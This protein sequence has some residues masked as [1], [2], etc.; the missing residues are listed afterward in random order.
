MTTRIPSASTTAQSLLSTLTS[1]STSSL[2]LPSKADLRCGTGTGG[3]ATGIMAG[4]CYPRPQLPRDG[5]DCGPRPLPTFPK[6]GCWSPL[7]LGALKELNKLDQSRG[8]VGADQLTDAIKNGT[9]DLDGQAASGEYRAFAEWAQ[10]NGA[11][12]TPEARKVMDI[13]SKYAAQAQAR[14]QSGIPQ[15]EYDKMIAEMKAVG[16]NSAKGA[17][18]RLDKMP[19]PISGEDFARA[20]RQGVGDRDGQTA[21]EAKAI[22]E[23]AEKNGSKLSPEAKEVLGMFN[24]AADK[25]AASGQKDISP[26]DWKQLLRDFRNVGDVSARKATEK[27]DKENGPIS[28]ED[29]LAAIKEGVS[30]KDGHSSTSELREFQKWAAKNQDRL[31]PEARKV[32]ET[33]E[34]AA[35]KAGPEG[36]TQKEFDSMLKEMGKFKTFRDDTMRTALEKLDDKSGKISGR[37]LTNAIKEGAG[38]FDGQAAGV[39]FA[40]AMKWAR[41][42]YDRLTPEARKVVDIYEK[43]ATKSLAAGNTGIPN[44]EFQKMLKEMERASNPVI[45]PTYIAA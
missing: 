31:T 18:S 37:D 19:S 22:R 40:D 12:L 24:K 20:I 14:G 21:A 4:G 11:R 7:D 3:D 16:D 38:D 26:S 25:A 15:A 44:N 34:K 45:R 36:M 8:P 28:G 13:Y 43:Y 35:K 23:W 29:M 5:W 41:Q 6:G 30:D 17:L 9:G 32:L 10:Q 2:T 33:Y 1:P 39:E 27:L 42:N